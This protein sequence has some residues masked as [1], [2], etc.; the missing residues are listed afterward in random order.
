MSPPYEDLLCLEQIISKAQAR[1]FSP[2]HTTK[3]IQGNTG[4]YQQKVLQ[5]RKKTFLYI[6]LLLHLDQYLY[7]KKKH[8]YVA[9]CRNQYIQVLL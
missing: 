5:G 3:E 2:A 4:C 8:R 6:L 7:I 9:F 1:I